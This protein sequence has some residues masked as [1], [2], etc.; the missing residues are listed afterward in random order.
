MPRQR[1]VATFSE[2][3]VQVFFLL[4]FWQMR[5]L[6]LLEASAWVGFERTALGGQ[7]DNFGFEEAPTAAIRH[8]KNST[9]RFRF[10]RAV[11][12]LTPGSPCT[13]AGGQSASA[14]RTP[15]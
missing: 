9:R 15:R 14:S 6:F 4:V 2:R 10:V 7:K 5:R 3:E 1:T 11:S 8:G 13:A 12:L